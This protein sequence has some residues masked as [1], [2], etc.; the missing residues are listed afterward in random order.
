[1]DYTPVVPDNDNDRRRGRINAN[2]R[3]RDRVDRDR[4]RDRFDRNRDRDRRFDGRR[5]RDRDWDRDRRRD[6]NVNINVYRRNFESPRRYR[7][8]KYRWPRGYDYRRYHYGQRLPVI[9]WRD[10]DYWLLDFIAFGLFAPPPGY[11]WVRYGPDALL[12]DTYSGEII[13]VRY[14]VFYV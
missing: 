3:D 1:M 5:D 8:G 13:Q 6:R 12:I 9:F 4:D 14:N 7:H 11:V 10:R 2:E